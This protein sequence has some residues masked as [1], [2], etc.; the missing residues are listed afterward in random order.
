MKMMNEERQIVSSTNKSNRC[1]INDCNHFH[2][3]KD[4]IVDW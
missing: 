3:D 1:Q 4:D 2:S